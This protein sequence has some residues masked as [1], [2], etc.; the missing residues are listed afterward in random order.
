VLF[1]AK[2]TEQV[3]L[4]EGK[5]GEME[6]GRNHINLLLTDAHSLSRAE[7]PEVAQ[8]FAMLFRVLRDVPTL[9]IP[10]IWFGKNFM[11]T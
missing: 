3:W 8:H 1:L 4:Q 6:R 7:G 2:V 9:G 5:E 10:A 11:A